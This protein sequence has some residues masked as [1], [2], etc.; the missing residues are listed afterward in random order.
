[1]AKNNKHN[2]STEQNN[3]KK[4][5]L[6]NIHDRTF[7]SSMSIPEVSKEFFETHLSDDLKSWVLL[8]TLKYE[9]TSFVDDELK[10]SICDL[11][12]RVRTTT[13]N[14]LYL[15]I[16]VEHQSKPLK[17]MSIKVLRYQLNIIEHAYKEH[18]KDDEKPLPLMATMVFYH[19]K[20]AYPY[21]TDIRDMVKAPRDKID[22][23]WFQPFRLI[24]TS[25]IPDEHLLAQ[26]YLGLL[27][28]TLKHIWEPDFEPYFGRIMV[29]FEGVQGQNDTALMKILLKY[30]ER[31]A[32][33]EPEV[34]IRIIEQSDIPEG[35]K[36]EVMS[37]VEQVRQ[38]SMAKGVQQGIEQGIEQGKQQKDI[39]YAKKMLA[40]GYSEQDILDM[41]GLDKKALIKIKETIN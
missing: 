15:T 16:L 19:G 10:E 14:D 3:E 33:L 38:Q 32:N 8:D 25:T 21:S 39:E 9:P 17:D 20:T 1:M 30:I 2:E 13:D 26:A 27:S 24:D 36:G 34:F 29:N 5:R 4:K 41:T 11:V 40:K 31:V 35:V 23:L 6:G 28:Y 7:R 22:A 37:V 12:Y 18:G